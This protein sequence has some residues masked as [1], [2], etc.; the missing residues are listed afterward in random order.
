MSRIEEIEEEVKDA[1]KLMIEH[2]ARRIVVVD[3]NQRP[4]GL[5]SLR[6]LALAPGGENFAGEIY[7]ALS[8]QAARMK[9][10]ACLGCTLDRDG[11]AGAFANDD[12]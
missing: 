11:I 6:D 9:L 1:M 12:P 7:A 3:G 8:P 4:V 5:V 10:L 2:R